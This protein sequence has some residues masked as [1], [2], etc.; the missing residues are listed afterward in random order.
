MAVYYILLA[1]FA[2]LSI[3]FYH[4]GPGRKKD[5]A[6]LLCAFL[7]LGSVSAFRYSVGYDYSTV[8]APAY[9][10]VLADP[11]GYSFSDSPF[12]PA[13]VLLE[14][15]IA[16]CTPNFQML[17]AVTSYLIVGL[18]TAFYWKYSANAAMSVLL[19][20]LL[21]Q[22]YCTMN[23]IRQSIAGAIALFALPFLKRRRFLPCLLLILLAAC[24]HQS[25]L[26]LIPAS[27]FCLLPFNRWTLAVYLFGAAAFYLVSPQ[28]LALVT[29][30]WYTD[31]PLASP[32]MAAAL[33]WP[34]T[35]VM[36]AAFLLLWWNRKRLLEQDR[37]NA[38]YLH[39]AFFAFFFTLM[40]TRHAI[41]D[42]FSLYFG[43]AF[44]ISIPLVY[45]LLREQFPSWDCLRHGATPQRRSAK[46]AAALL[47]TVVFGGLAAHHYALRQDHHGVVPY[48]TIFAQSF[49][50][51]YLESLQGSPGSQAFDDLLMEPEQAPAGSIQPSQDPPP[52]SVSLPDSLPEGIP[53]PTA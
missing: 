20:L 39:Y 4:N 41:L 52:V 34:F 35:L 1:V 11:A 19:F 43:F 7:I 29:R 14:K 24:F 5:A 40:G 45:S 18:L 9:E 3:F 23:F 25:A 47:L 28:L 36:L 8:Y 38:V 46:Q 16:W 15:M 50:A 33:E 53:M 22:Y 49:Y 21:S 44:P 26:I 17:F 27:L 10:A 32:H 51:E 42:R 6:F 30:Y 12:E 37:G 2:I 48:Q 31:Y 13:F